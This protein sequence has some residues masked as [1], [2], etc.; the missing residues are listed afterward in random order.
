ME[1][2]N[3]GQMDRVHRIG[4]ALALLILPILLGTAFAL[5]FERLADFFVFKLSYEPNS[6]SAFMDT[7]LDPAASWRYTLSHSVGY[8]AIPFLIPAALY[9]AALLYK[10]RP[11]LA[12][13]GASLVCIGAVFMGGLFGTW[14]SF[15]AVGNV[16]PDQLSGAAAALEELTRMQGPLL[17]T[18]MLSS[19]SLLGFLL[20]AGG[21]FFSSE[22]PKWSSALIFIGYLFITVFT[23]LDNWMFIGA[24]LVLIGSW[25]IA[26]RAFRGE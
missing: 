12:I 8:A 9:L 21:L 6:A 18:T 19:L 16:A 22:L 14:L 10:R 15:A 24:L 26:L 20:L 23:D 2:K 11:W 25:P 4:G 13:T 3:S 7:L 17:W 1:A 5:H